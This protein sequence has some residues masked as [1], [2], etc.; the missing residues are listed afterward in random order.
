M[1]DLE[2]RKQR[3]G[4]KKVDKDRK[5]SERQERQRRREV[6]TNGDIPVVAGGEMTVHELIHAKV[7]VGC[8]ACLKLWRVPGKEWN[9]TGEQKCEG[10][11]G[12]KG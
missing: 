4:I 2:I 12:G 1:T 7:T 8:P 9:G 3:R 10:C 6:A 11:E 5:R